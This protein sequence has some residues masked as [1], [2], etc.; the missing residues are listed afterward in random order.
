MSVIVSLCQNNETWIGSD[1][2]VSRQG[3]MVGTMAKWCTFKDCA[4]GIV[5][6]LGF[7]LEAQ[8]RADELLG[9]MPEVG[10]LADRLKR[11]WKECGFEPR[12]ATDDT[13][14]WWDFQGIYVR[15]NQQVW[16]LDSSLQW[17]PQ[18]DCWSE[19]S[20]CDYALG[21]LFSSR[22]AGQGPRERLQTALDAACYYTTSCRSPLFLWCL[23]ASGGIWE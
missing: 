2:L 15:G 9:G 18:P 12:P 1:G 8:R 23:G 4:L 13:L 22:N 19:G 16:S 20:G 11:L 7:L 10:E 6:D 17:V 21:A 3:Q 5:G 14:P